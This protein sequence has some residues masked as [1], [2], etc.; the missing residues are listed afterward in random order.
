MLNDDDM[1][2]TG[3]AAVRLLKMWQIS[4]RALDDVRAAVRESGESLA[5]GVRSLTCKFY[6]QLLYRT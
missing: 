3:S 4:M 5:R 6:P 1:T 2:N